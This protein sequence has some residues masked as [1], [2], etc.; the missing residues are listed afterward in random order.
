[1]K[2]AT[3]T[4]LFQLTTIVYGLLTVTTIVLK[5]VIG[6]AISGSFFVASFLATI[7]LIR[8]IKKEE[9]TQ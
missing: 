8:E 5:E 2:T 9:A 7:H 3:L 6:T 4:K 1:M